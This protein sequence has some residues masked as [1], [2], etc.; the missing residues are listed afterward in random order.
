MSNNIM[1]KKTKK[2]Q[3]ET[4]LPRTSKIRRLNTMSSL[5]EKWQ[6]TK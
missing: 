1:M 6:K 4:K 3:K 2:G 5:E